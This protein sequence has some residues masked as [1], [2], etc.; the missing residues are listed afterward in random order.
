MEAC[1]FLGCETVLEKSVPWLMCD[2]CYGE[3]CDIEDSE[4]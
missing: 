2:A 4:F 1:G 3:A